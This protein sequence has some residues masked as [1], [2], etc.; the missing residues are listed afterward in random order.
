MNGSNALIYTGGGSGGGIFIQCG[1][2]AGGGTIRALGGNSGISD[3]GGGGGGRIA[4]SAATVSNFGGQISAKGGTGLYAFPDLNR[5]S[6]APGTIYL[7]DWGILPAVLS[8]GGAARVAAATGIVSSLMVSNYSLLLEWGWETNRLRAG[9]I[10]VKNTGKIMHFWNTDTAAPWA[11]D[12]GIF[13]ECSNLTVEAGGEINGQGLGFGGGAV[14]AS[15]YGPG[16]GIYS[17]SRGGGGGYGGG[18]G[19]GDNAGSTA[20]SAYGVNTNP[21]NAGSGG[22][23]GYD[24]GG[25]GGGGYA[26]IVAA[27]TVT[28]DGV[29]NMNGLASGNIYSGGGSGGGLV[30]QCDTL[31]GSGTIQANGGN[32]VGTAG[33][34]GGGGRIMVLATNASSFGGQLSAKSGT[35][36]TNFPDADRLSAAPGTV[37]L[38]DWRLLPPAL[39]NGGAAR[40]AAPTG[41]AAAV[42]VS[43]YTLLLEWGWETNRL[44]AGTVTVKNTGKIMHGWNTD[45][46]APW[47]EDGGIFIECSNLTVE[48][49]GEINGQ[50]LGFGGGAVNVSGYGPGRGIYSGSRGGGGGYG[51]TGGVGSDASSYGGGTYGFSNTPANAGSGGSGG[52]NGGGG[53]GGGYVKIVA[54]GPV[55]VDGTIN[56]NGWASGGNYS[57]GGSGGGIL[58]I[59]SG[60][61]GKGTIRAN[62]G[63]DGGAG[64]GGGGGRIA[65]YVRGMPFYTGGNLLATPRPAGGS[66]YSYG[67]AGTLVLELSKPRGTVWSTW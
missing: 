30:I 40:L 11:E 17:G 28:V 61:L 67:G 58:I 3:S 33:G 54:S 29:I 52:Y 60:I 4:I 44:Q 34:G 20:G 9:T 8:N 51:G 46:A 39:T 21:V 13:I 42:T 5:K 2:L 16:L 37:Y 25:G 18:G 65:L 31:A 27:G 62:G 12:G 32:C 63:S 43:N 36:Y 7:S 64:G 19:R 23:G 55:L 14:N 22:S 53:P 56:M 10:T 66:G 45:T 59:C 6:A 50:G 15:G 48:A 24:S 38:S 49:G 57:G 35:G 26:K 41:M 1:S 47:A